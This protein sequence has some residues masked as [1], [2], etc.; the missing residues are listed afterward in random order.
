[1]SPCVADCVVLT[2]AMFEQWSRKK[3]IRKIS[4]ATPHAQGCGLA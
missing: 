4:Q 2:K 3:K 1:M